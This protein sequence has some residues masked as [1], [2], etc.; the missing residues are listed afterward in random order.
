MAR[1]VELWGGPCDGE[2]RA[3]LSAATSLEVA[4]PVAPIP[5][6]AHVSERGI[7]LLS[8]DDLPVETRR[9]RYRQDPER[10]NRLKWCG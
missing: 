4:V 5:K 3:I 10:P 7:H 8:P 1:T 6:S 2:V 9:G